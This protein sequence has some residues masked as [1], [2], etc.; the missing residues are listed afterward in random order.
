MHER[1]EK[2]RLDDGRKTCAILLGR[3]KAERYG[4][5]RMRHSGE[6]LESIR[7]VAFGEGWWGMPEKYWN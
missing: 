1:G 6:R 2:V 5:Q 7:K 3:N 4:K